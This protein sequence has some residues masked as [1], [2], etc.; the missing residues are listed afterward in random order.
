[1]ESSALKAFLKNSK[2]SDTGGGSMSLKGS[3]RKRRGSLKDK[4]NVVETDSKPVRRRFSAVADMDFEAYL[5]GEEGPRSKASVTP[6]TSAL[7]AVCRVEYD[8]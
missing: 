4:E 8:L 7:F 6:T 2:V 5:R 3:W 1:M